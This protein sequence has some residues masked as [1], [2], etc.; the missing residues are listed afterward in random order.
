[1]HGQ[2]RTL[3]DKDEALHI[4]HEALGLE[5]ALRRRTTT[6]GPSASA[7]VNGQS[8]SNSTVGQSER[9]PDDEASNWN[10]AMA[11]AKAGHGGAGVE[12]VA[13]LEAGP[14]Q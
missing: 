14:C 13:A 6:S 11:V 4:H 5:P 1:L 8:R 10:L 9:Q 3:E 7:A 12:A 2:A